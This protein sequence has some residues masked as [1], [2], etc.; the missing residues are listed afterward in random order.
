[1]A[2]EDREQTTI[3]MSGKMKEK[4]KSHSQAMGISLNDF[5]MTAINEFLLQNE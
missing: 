2:R 5:I 4:I 1:M 3:R